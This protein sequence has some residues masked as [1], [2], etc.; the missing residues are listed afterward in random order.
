MN[1]KTHYIKILD[2]FADDVFC[3]RKRFEIRKND[4]GYQAFDSVI[5]SVVNKHGKPVNHPLNDCKLMITYVLNGY[6]LKDGYCAFG[7]TLGGGWL[8][9]S[10][11]C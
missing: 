1:C 10:N 6:G 9:D 2:S 4:R 11:P 5:F 7:L 3:G 8:Y